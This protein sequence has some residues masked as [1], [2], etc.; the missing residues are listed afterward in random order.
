MRGMAMN[1]RR[2]CFGGHWF[3]LQ[4]LVSSGAT[5]DIANFCLPQWATGY[6]T[7]GSNSRAYVQIVDFEVMAY[8]GDMGTK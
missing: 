1:V 7:E 4:M 2:V 3:G 6:K 8:Q 5:L